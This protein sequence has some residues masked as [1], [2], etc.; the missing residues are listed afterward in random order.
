MPLRNSDMDVCCYCTPL[1]VR[2][3]ISTHV[4]QTLVVHSFSTVLVATVNTNNTTNVDHNHNLHEG[5]GPHITIPW[6]QWLEG[7]MRLCAT[8]EDL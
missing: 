8:S 2:S 7:T 6:R 3:F 5:S 4:Y 1:G